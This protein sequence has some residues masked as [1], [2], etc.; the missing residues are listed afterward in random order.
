MRQPDRRCSRRKL[1]STSG[2]GE[3][4]RKAPVLGVLMALLERTAIHLARLTQSRRSFDHRFFG[5]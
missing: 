3:C 5:I 4:R 2:S 1:S